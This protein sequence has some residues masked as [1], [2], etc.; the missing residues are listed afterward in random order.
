MLP[1]CVGMYLEPPTSISAPLSFQENPLTV[2]EDVAVQ[3]SCKTELSPTCRLESNITVAEKGGHRTKKGSCD[4]THNQN[5]YQ[6]CIHTRPQPRVCSGHSRTVP[7]PAASSPGTR[8]AKHSAATASRVIPPPPSEQ[9]LRAR[10][11]VQPFFKP[12]RLGDWNC[13]R[14]SASDEQNP[15]CSDFPLGRGVR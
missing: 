11:S 4:L 13:T 5:T 12:T 9:Q 7:S 3:V 6:H 15:E 14:Y 1:V 2:R 8:S 10:L